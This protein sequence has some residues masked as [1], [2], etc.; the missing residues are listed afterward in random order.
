MEKTQRFAGFRRRRA[1]PGAIR[2]ERDVSPRLDMW[3][4]V[5]E[6]CWSNGTLAKGL[7][8]T[9]AAGQSLRGSHQVGEASHARDH[10]CGTQMDE[11]V[12]PSPDHHC[13]FERQTQFAAERGGEVPFHVGILS[14]V[15]EGP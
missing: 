8:E 10:W 7:R 6:R 3:A 12:R 4:R 14:F 11:N 1:L 2:P 15:G 5:D 9:D 13:V